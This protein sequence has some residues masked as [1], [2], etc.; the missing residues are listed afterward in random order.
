MN[1]ISL[2]LLSSLFLLGLFACNQVR[3]DDTPIAKVGGDFIY[4]SELDFALSSVPPREINMMGK[5]GAKAKLFAS[6]LET[7]VMAAAGQKYLKDDGHVQAQLKKLADRDLSRFY[8]QRFLYEGLG[9]D[10][11]ALLTFYK[12]NQDL[13]K[14]DTVLPDFSEIRM[15]VAAK[16][17]AKEAQ[18][19]IEAFY[20]ENAP[21]YQEKAQVDLSII[22]NTDKKVIE[23]VLAQLSAGVSFDSLA[24]QYSTHP[25]A[26]QNSGK[27]GAVM[28]GQWK[29]ETSRIPNIDSLLFGSN[30]VAKD[31]LS[32]ILE[33][34]RPGKDSVQLY[35]L[36]KVNDY[37]PES[38]PTLASI[39]EKVTTDY[40]NQLRQ[41]LPT[42][43]P[44][45]LKE[46]AKV[47]Y[48]EIPPPDA[49]KYY[50]EHKEEYKTTKGYELFHI[51][52]S[53]SAKLAAAIASV[54]DG[55]AF[56]AKAQEIS[57]NAQ[58]KA[59]NGKLG[60][61]K[62][63]HAL[64]YG[65]GMMHRLF[66]DL[67]DKKPGFV[68]A[69]IESP[70]VKGAYHAFYLDKVV[71]P[72]VKPFDRVQKAIEI[73]L[74]K[75]ADIELDPKTVLAKSNGKVLV[76]EADVI[77]L[78]KEVP[79]Q[80]RAG[81]PRERLRDFLV[82]WALM[83]EAAKKQNLDQSVEFLALSRLR[84]A[85]LWG[86]E[87]RDSLFNK[88]LAIPEAEL[89][90]VHQENL[91]VFHDAPFERV[92][93]N[94]AIFSMIP[95][96]AFE[97]EFVGNPGKYPKD[98]GDDWKA[99]KKELFANLMQ[100]WAVQ[101]KD[102][103]MEQLRTEVGVEILD[104]ALAEATDPKALLE[105]A[106]KLMGERKFKEARE[107]YANIRTQYPDDAEISP[108]VAMA[109]GQL[110]M[111]MKQFDAAASEFRMVYSM[112]PKFADAYKAMFMEGFVYYEHTKNDEKAKA[113]FSEMLKKYP[114]TDLSDDAE[115][116][117]N[118]LNSGRTLMQKILEKAAANA[119]SLAKAEAN[120]APKAQTET[121]SQN[122]TIPKAPAA[123]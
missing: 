61:V 59:L 21:K 26:A 29:N 114:G 66:A 101:A 50:E 2:V 35:V 74:T 112:Y 75:G 68:S 99:Y 45:M 110:Q 69:V 46:A 24:K 78:K 83:S 89:R 98:K 109:L 18:S 41:Q 47:E 51:Q 37:K 25:Q 118:D 43:A 60:V 36:L 40:I 62:T 31:S 122:E 65:I 120:A 88:N 10:D 1:K 30:R 19:E 6:L 97:A 79:P 7:R 119:D 64:P 81:F 73:K 90:K 52:S 57:E 58:T 102:R 103:R 96:E 42:E 27:I 86:Q 80:Q 56:L 100:P 14:Q 28:Q 72:Q 93:R 87:F 63:G 117:L 106:S 39:Q 82:E 95:N 107:A 23:T 116:L 91:A 123:Q 34:T 11:N 92:Q 13:F 20:K 54:Q 77:E 70:D 71:E 67:N 44:K 53:D 94:V 12:N 84:K 105:K 113:V 8:Q 108:Q 33:Y 16:L 111:E 4:Q 49:Q 15:Q 121:K 17:K 22:E 85:D 32:G 76:T 5:E 38:L 55:A 104:S 115:A 3:R 9:Y 48:P